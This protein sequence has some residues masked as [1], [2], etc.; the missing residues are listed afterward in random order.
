ME[1]EDERK[2]N[3]RSCQ[4]QTVCSSL[5]LHS[6]DLPDTHPSSKDWVK[7]PNPEWTVLPT[8]QNT[9]T[10]AGHKTLEGHGNGPWQTE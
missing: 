9:M 6:Q 10:A 1:M 7:S 3:P 4:C 8:I 5:S 2:G